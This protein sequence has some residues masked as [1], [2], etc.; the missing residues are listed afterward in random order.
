[1]SR[2]VLCIG[3]T[4]LPWHVFGRFGELDACVRQPFILG[5][6]VIDR[7]VNL[8]ALRMFERLS[9]NENDDSAFLLSADNDGSGLGRPPMT[10]RPIFSY[11]APT[12][13]RL[14]TRND[15]Q[16]VIIFAI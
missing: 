8:K 12:S 2:R 6:D 4:P 13:L 5:I 3:M 1:M 9:R 15:S 7:K 16:P 14:R 10:C 11:Q